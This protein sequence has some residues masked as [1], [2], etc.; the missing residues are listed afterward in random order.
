MSGIILL[1]S[2]GKAPGLLRIR[3]AT[4]SLLAMTSKKTFYECIKIT[5]RKKGVTCVQ[6]PD[7]F[8]VVIFDLMKLR[9][10]V[11]IEMLEK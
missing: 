1:N 3:L 8:S 9:G 2:K 7:I 10:S 4:A 11:L 5:L 6:N